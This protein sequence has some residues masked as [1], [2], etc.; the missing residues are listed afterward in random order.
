[1]HSK[2]S[3]SVSTSTVL[4]STSISLTRKAGVVL[5]VIGMP[6]RRLQAG[7]SG[8]CGG[9]SVDLAAPGGEDIDVSDGKL[10]ALRQGGT[11]ADE[12]VFEVRGGWVQ[13]VK[14][15]RENLLQLRAVAH[16]ACTAAEF[17]RSIVPSGSDT[18]TCGRGTRPRSTTSTF[19][20]HAPG[21]A[22][23]SARGR[24]WRSGLSN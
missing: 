23:L 20:S 2:V 3:V 9:E 1:M 12:S 5:P 11:S 6:G 15:Q 7:E 21:L 18:Q 4:A 14:D 10:D 8:Q 13:P 17:H 24:G 19:V 16:R 22:E